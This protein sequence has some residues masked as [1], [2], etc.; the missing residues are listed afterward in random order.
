MDSQREISAELP[1]GVSA[2]GADEFCQY[3]GGGARLP[4]EAEWKFAATSRGTV[5]AGAPTQ[6]L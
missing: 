4:S 1:N 5:G 3:L 6:Q 2:E